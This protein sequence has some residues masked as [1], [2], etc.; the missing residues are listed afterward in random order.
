[1]AKRSFSTTN[2]TPTL[3]ADT[4]ALTNATYMSLKGGS[5]TQKIDVLEVY[6]YGMAAASAPTPLVLARASTVA[7]TPTALAAP[8]TD[9]P[10]DPASAALAAPPVSFTAAAAG[11]QRSAVVT[12][13]R[14]ALGINT[15]G[16]SYRWNAAPTQQWGI[17]G[18]TASFGETILSALNAGTAGALGVGILYEPY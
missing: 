3:Q 5:S 12:D 1:M 8:A 6:V 2:F 7:T 11:S 18:N 14:L 17:L 10:M 9:G 13:A 4:T 16:G 15:F